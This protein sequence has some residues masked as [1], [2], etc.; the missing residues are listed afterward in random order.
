M[1]Y[2]GNGHSPEFIINPFESTLFL[3]KSSSTKDR[4]QVD[5]LALDLV[6]VL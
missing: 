2:T 5:P 1:T 4:F 6:E 3:R